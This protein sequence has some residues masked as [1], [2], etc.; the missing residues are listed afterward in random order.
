MI[1]ELNPSKLPCTFESNVPTRGQNFDR[2]LLVPIGIPGCG[3][4][5]LAIALQSLI[6][7]KHTQSDDITTKKTGPAFIE[8]VKE[9]LIQDSGSRVV[10]AD[11]NNHLKNHREALVALTSKLKDGMEIKT[12]KGSKGSR[13]TKMIR[14][15]V[16]LIAITWDLDRHSASALHEIASRRVVKRGENHQSL[17][18][19]LTAGGLQAHETILWRFIK[20]FEEFDNQ[21][22]PEDRGFHDSIELKFGDSI[23]SNLVALCAR[24]QHLIPD[25]FIGRDLSPSRI[26][27][28]LRDA[29]DY[30]PRIKKEMKIDSALQNPRYFGIKLDNV[31]LA[32]LIKK[33]FD[34]LIS[35]TKSETVTEGLRYV[36][37]LRENHRI[38]P[39]PHITLVHENQI[40]EP[41]NDPD[42]ERM[43]SLWDHCKSL[44][45][46]NQPQIRLE[47]GPNL[48]WN[49]R[50]MVIE[51]R[52]MEA[53]EQLV[54]GSSAQ[55]AI[56]ALSDPRPRSS[57]RSTIP[58]TDRD[59]DREDGSENDR[60]TACRYHVTV[61][62]SDKSIRPIEGLH[63]FNRFFSNPPPPDHRLDHDGQR[64]EVDEH[65]RFVDVDPI[66]VHG[67]IKGLT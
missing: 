23:E 12:G 14:L 6:N 13:Q 51:A 35:K 46:N 8:N 26:G 4:T 60:P 53:S 61:G 32:S 18:P 65:I 17:R 37:E 34:R 57:A 52:L 33:S 3:K 43:K 58:S 38:I 45:L 15:N 29:E 30:K 54:H 47:L 21:I 67:T 41:A 19:E 22:N 36:E 59:L 48:I 2:V 63:L 28:A 31:D 49:D 62:T 66:R 56:A 24:L 7:C 39:T 1:D 11:K 5:T 27:R 64:L 44:V 10:I 40:Q 50:V 42:H 20:T 16:R 9:L 25:Q 55:S